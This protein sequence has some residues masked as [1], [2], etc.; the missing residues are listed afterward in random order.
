MAFHQLLDQWIKGSDNQTNTPSFFD[1]SFPLHPK[2]KDFMDYKVV[3]RGKIVDF[4]I[5]STA[6]KE[7][8]SEDYVW[9]IEVKEGSCFA[10]LKDARGGMKELS[11]Q[12]CQAIWKNV[13]TK[14]LEQDLDGVGVN[15][16]RLSNGNVIPIIP[17]KFKRYKENNQRKSKASRE[18]KKRK[19]RLEKDSV[20]VEHQ[21]YDDHVDL[22]CLPQTDEELLTSVIIVPPNFFMT[23]RDTTMTTSKEDTQQGLA[24]IFD[25]CRRSQ[26]A[27]TQQQ[28]E[29]LFDGIDT[30]ADFLRMEHHDLLIKWFDYFWPE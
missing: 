11:I 22:G 7:R 13:H 5:Y 28:K 17:D 26:L 27:M 8:L 21:F 24:T 15:R 16:R 2:K 30:Y 25:F 19:I 12:S 29:P 1:T 6:G 3:K 23:K 9:W 4:D 14:E 20:M 18:R 10:F